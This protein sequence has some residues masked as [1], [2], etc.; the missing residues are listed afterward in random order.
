MTQQ[1]YSVQTNTSTTPTVLEFEEIKANPEMLDELSK[2][3][4][5]VHLMGL[6][7]TFV[8]A[9]SVERN[10]SPHTTRAYRVDLSDFIRWSQDKK[11]NPLMVNHKQLR[12]YLASLSKAQYAQSTI[13]R[14]LCSLRSWYRWL[15]VQGFI[16]SNPADLLD[17]PRKA[18]KLP[19]R[20]SAKDMTKLLKVYSEAACIEEDR[21]RTPVD[22]RNQAMLEC[23]YAC[24]VRISEVSG[25]RLSSV[26]FEEKTIK[27]FGKG[28]K[29]RIVPIHDLSLAALKLY[30]DWA[31]PKIL[32]GKE[33]EYFFVSTR[34]NQMGTDAIRKMFKA[35]LIKAGLDTSLSPHDMR[36]TFA[37][38]MLEGGADLRS[39]QEMLGH[40]SP[41]TTQIYTHVSPEHIL[42]E[43][44]QAHPRG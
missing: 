26:N 43:H 7:D 15:N 1:I 37:S 36:H 20:I 28:S 18:K 39:V 21:K 8:Y 33:S 25:L 40:A 6:V 30:R 3:E 35:S 22:V 27:V 34:G 29:E 2:K 11:I 32:Q 19:R 42:K 41:S 4:R 23:M 9:L 31:R 44:H 38:D 24:G 12:R 16:E 13:N 17:G 10:A 5:V 14:C